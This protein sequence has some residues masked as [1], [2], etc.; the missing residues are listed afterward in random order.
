MT[1]RNKILMYITVLLGTV[2]A[3]CNKES[4]EHPADIPIG[5]AVITVTMNTEQTP[6]A[7]LRDVHLYWFGETGKLARHDY[8]SSME[9]LALSRITLPERSYTVVAVLNVGANF[10]ISAVR[11]EMS[12]IDLGTFSTHVK[13]QESNYPDMLTGTQ[14]H[15]VKKEKQLV[16]IDL[17][18]KSSGIK[19]LSVEV[20]VTI[21]SANLPSYVSGRTTTPALRGVAYIFKKDD[22][23][24]FAIERAMLEATATE[25]VYKMKLW[26]FQGEYD[27]NLWVDYSTDAA[28]DNHYITTH[29][30]GDVIRILDKTHY[31][32]NDDSRDAFS[33]RISLSVKEKENSPQSVAMHRPLAKYKLVA[34]DVEKYKRIQASKNLPELE[35]LRVFIGY[36]GFLPTAYSI[37]EQRPAD[38]DQGYYY[39]TVLGIP[40]TES[41]DVAKDFV[42]VNGSES[43]VSVTILFKDA[44]DK[45]VSGTKGVKIA[46]RAGQLTTVSGDFLTSGLGS[47]I[48]ID[49]EWDDDI[50]VEF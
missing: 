42:F 5:E 21:P 4:H 14:H 46:Y 9:A 26:L 25:G 48:D 22:P 36:E 23:T 6:N 31:R 13:A 3:S 19:D 44:N 16:Y 39:N 18:S 43:S 37:S 50:N 49:T 20:L 29:D 47:G 17:K 38:A 30:K 12:D 1:M 10:E 24:L 8:Y 11:S 15:I 41:V 32:G 45:V 7:P 2:L 27:V 33:Q 40:T 28:T 34:T 35:D